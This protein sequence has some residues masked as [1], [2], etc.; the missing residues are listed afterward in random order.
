MNRNLCY[1]TQ[2]TSCIDNLRQVSYTFENC[3]VNEFGYMSQSA[4]HY[5]R[6]KSYILSGIHAGDWC[7]GAKIPSENELANQFSF[8][9]M[10]VNRAVKELEHEGFL[11]RIQGKG[12]FVSQ[13]RPLHSVL[14]IR[15]IAEEI[16][17]RGN[18]YTCRVIKLERDTRNVNIRS[19]MQLPDRAK[20]FYSSVVHLENSVPV[21]LEQRWVNPAIAPSYLKQNFLQLTPHDYLMSV[22]MFTH[23]QHRIEATLPSGQTRRTLKMESG[24]P[25][26][27]IHRQT[28]IDKTVATFAHLHHPGSRF[29]I[30][31]EMNPP[32]QH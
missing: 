22:A 30:S 2:I 13:P 11:E 4:L 24:E 32:S 1:D 23:A 19:E 25:C 18:D 20:L 10:T 9:R 7:V 16:R 31:S 21:Q 6:V 27:L 26:L 12:T 15:S 3:P 28:W 8:S 29:Q 5:E 17:A 14:E